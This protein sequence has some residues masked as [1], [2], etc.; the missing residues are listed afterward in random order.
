M[1]NPPQLPWITIGMNKK[2]KTLANK[3][4]YVHG[5]GSAMNHDGKSMSIRPRSRPECLSN[6]CLVV[7]GL[8]PELNIDEFKAGIINKA[9]YDI[10]FKFIQIL[11]REDQWYLTVAIELNETDYKKL[12]DANFWDP[13][14]HIRK[15]LGQRWWR[16]ELMPPR[17]PRQRLAYE[18]RKNIPRA[19]WGCAATADSNV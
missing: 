12:F 5:K 15:F 13:H 2:K 19:Q 11:S 14:C 3:A 16:E 17:Q 4:P 9:G 8:N 10:D 6:E 7:A 1:S 18:E